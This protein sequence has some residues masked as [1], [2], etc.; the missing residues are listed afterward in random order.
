MCEEPGCN[1]PVKIIP[2]RDSKKIL[3]I[4]HQHFCELYKNSH[5]RRREDK[6]I[7]KDG[8]VIIWHNGVRMGEHRVVMQ[9]KLG[10]EL[11]KPE[12]VHHK[13]G[14]RSDNRL[15]NLELWSTYQPAGQRIE[16]KVEYAKEILK[17]YEP[18]ALI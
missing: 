15:N 14:N 11:I 9:K 3:K 8:Y 10:R 18:R 1:N 12:S 2:H 16:D 17:L 7:D 5:T 4:C 13:N 6:Y